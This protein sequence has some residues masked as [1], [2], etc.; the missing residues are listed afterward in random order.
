MVPPDNSS[1]HA[2]RPE[3]E[4]CREG[5]GLQLLLEQ[6]R[7]MAADGWRYGR[8]VMEITLVCTLGVPLVFR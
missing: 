4:M 6:C 2:A 3:I 1:I 5:G 7:Q 8:P